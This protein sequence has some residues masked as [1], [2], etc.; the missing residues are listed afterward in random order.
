M[1]IKNKIT[2]T[3]K[4]DDEFYRLCEM[5][6]ISRK[7]LS[8]NAKRLL[9]EIEEQDEFEAEITIM[10]EIPAKTVLES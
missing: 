4:N 9:K 7:P 6:R 10:C 5:W 3:T 1:T 2:I 8:E